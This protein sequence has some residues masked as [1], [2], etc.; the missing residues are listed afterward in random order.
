MRSIALRNHGKARVWL[1]ALPE[2]PY[3]VSERI[4][5]HLKGTHGSSSRSFDAGVELFLPRGGRFMYGLLG[6]S[7]RNSEGEILQLAID[8]S[9]VREPFFPASLAASLDGVRLGL[10]AEYAEAVVNGLTAA[11]GGSASF[12]PGHLLINRAAHSAVG[13]SSQ[14]FQ[15]LAAILV[16]VIRIGRFDIP[17]DHL[18]SL[19]DQQLVPT[20]RVQ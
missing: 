18:I 3:A 12:A 7:F 14:I 6:G 10:P 17:D 1:D 2:A 13:S 4:H 16:D 19:I 20:T 15:A 5:R 9:T 8:L 11:A